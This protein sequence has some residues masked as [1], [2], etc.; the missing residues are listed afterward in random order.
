MDM[1]DGLGGQEAG[2]DMARAVSKP[3][4]GELIEQFV[5]RMIDAGRTP[6][7]LRSQI[8]ASLAAVR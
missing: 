8:A 4:D 2:D 6:L 7:L 3:L 5:A 1:L